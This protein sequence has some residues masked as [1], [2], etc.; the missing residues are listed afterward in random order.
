MMGKIIEL[1]KKVNSAYV[2]VGVGDVETIESVRTVSHLDR[3][4]GKVQTAT[5]FQ[6]ELEEETRREKEKFGIGNVGNVNKWED[7][8]NAVVGM[9]THERR[10]EEEQMKRKPLHDA[11]A[12]MIRRE[13]EIQKEKMGI[14]ETVEISNI[15]PDMNI[16]ETVTTELP[17]QEQ[18]EIDIKF[19]ID[20]IVAEEEVGKEENSVE[21]EPEPL[22]IPHLEND[23]KKVKGKFAK[24][25]QGWLKEQKELKEKTNK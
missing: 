10:L 15:M 12:D 4:I 8:P 20:K 21:D 9:V 17:D 19:D 1:E 7:E 3:G 22:S 2:D 25:S 13:V 23:T 11:S 5:E 18:K 16:N 6:R 24:G 14:V